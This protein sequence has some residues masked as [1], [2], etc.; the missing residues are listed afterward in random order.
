MELPEAFLTVKELIEDGKLKEFKSIFIYVKKK[1][2]NAKMG[3]NYNRFLRFVQNPKLIDFEDVYNIAHVFQV[4][5]RQISELIHKQIDLQKQI[6]PK[7][8]SK[9]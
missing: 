4:S 7:K 8:N 1:H 2:V 5:P 6:D 3:A 9:T